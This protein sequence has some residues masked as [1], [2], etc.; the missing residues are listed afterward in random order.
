MDPITA[1][2]LASSIVTFVDFATKIVSGTYEVYRSGATDD[3]VHVDTI[4]EDLTEITAHL[5]VAIPGKTANEIALKN[6][7]AKCEVVSGKLQAIL[8]SLKVSGD[9]TMWKSLKVRIKSMRESKDIIEL[10]KQLADYRS[11]IL[12]RLTVMLG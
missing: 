9:R 1:I 11:Q 2:S 3:N 5:S 10:E 8:D 4:V 6:L 7:A 12:T